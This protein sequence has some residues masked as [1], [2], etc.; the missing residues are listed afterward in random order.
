MPKSKRDRKQ[1]GLRG[2]HIKLPEN[3]VAWMAY[4]AR[5]SRKSQAQIIE[6]G[7][8]LVYAKAIAKDPKQ[9]ALDDDPAA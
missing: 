3:M 7:I 4:H 8:R 1:D 9:P 6:E 2:C 5:K